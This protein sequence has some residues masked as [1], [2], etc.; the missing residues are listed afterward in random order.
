MTDLEDDRLLPCRQLQLARSLPDDLTGDGHAR[1][2]R[3]RVDGDGR[4]ALRQGSRDGIGRALERG[5]ARREVP[6]HCPEREHER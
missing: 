4:L 5:Y 6:E 2:R 3:Q 1:L